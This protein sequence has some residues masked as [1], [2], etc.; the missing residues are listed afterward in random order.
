MA[1]AIVF[2]YDDGQDGAGLPG[3]IRTIIA[4]WTSDA[5]GA[6]AGTSRKI[7]GML[8]KA[9]TI[10]LTS[11]TDNYDIDLTDDDSVN[12][13]TACKTGLHDRDTATTEETYLFVLNQDSTAL[14]MGRGPVINN[15]LTVT[16]ANAGNVKTGRLK[17]YYVAR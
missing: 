15:P 7:N 3:I 6:A 8:L 10:P 11:P 13:L 17:L 14:S 16:I 5:A 12:V 4:D 2:T 1:G 9:V